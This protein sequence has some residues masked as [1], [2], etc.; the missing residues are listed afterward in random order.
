ML[1]TAIIGFDRA[2]RTLSGIA[3]S[4]RAIPGHD[5]SESE[6]SEQERAPLGRAD[7]RQPHR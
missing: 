7:A 6:M 1:A 4:S 5:L 3:R 2:L